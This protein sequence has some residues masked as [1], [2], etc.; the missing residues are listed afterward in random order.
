MDKCIETFTGSGVI[1]QESGEAIVVATATLLDN[2]EASD[3]AELLS[4]LMLN[5]RTISKK[6]KKMIDTLIGFLY[7]S[8]RDLCYG[9]R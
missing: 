5:H 1:S 9:G 4:T 2:H 3:Y 8:E 7:T 6:E